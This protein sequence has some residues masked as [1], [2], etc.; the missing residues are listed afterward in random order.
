MV[1]SVWQVQLVE[2]KGIDTLIIST[3]KYWIIEYTYIECQGLHASKRN[4]YD[5]FTNYI[6]LKIIKIQRIVPD[7]GPEQEIS[8]G[9]AAI[10]AERKLHWNKVGADPQCPWTWFNW[11]NFIPL[12]STFYC[13]VTKYSCNYSPW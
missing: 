13:Y 2:S 5:G 6:T 3:Q 12:G 1:W 8:L 9:L 4:W 7:W 11:C 10:R